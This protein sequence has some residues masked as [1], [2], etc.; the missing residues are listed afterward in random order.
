MICDRNIKIIGARQHNLNNV[1]LNIPYHRLTAVTGVSGCGKSSLVFDTV[2]AESQRAFLAGLN[3]S[4]YGN[5][6][7]DKPDVDRVEN[8]CPALSL[9]QNYYNC[10]PR[11]TVGTLTEIS[12][13]LRSLFALVLNYEEGQIYKAKDFSFNNPKVWCSACC[14][15]GEGYHVAVPALI[16]DESKT[17]NKGGITYFKGNESSLEYRTLKMA[18]EAFS[19][20]MDT[21]MSELPKDKLNILLNFDGDCVF[22]VRYKS[23][24]K[25]YRKKTVKFKGAITELKHKLKNINV[26][27]TFRSIEKFIASGKCQ[28]CGGMRLKPEILVK[29]VCGC[30]I[31]HVEKMS[32]EDVSAWLGRVREHY[33]MGKIIKA[34]SDIESQITPKLQALVDLK[35]G[36]LCLDRSVPTL[37]RGE[38]QRV[39]VADQLSCS[40]VG[41]LYILDEP[42]KGLH[43]RDIGCIIKATRQL[44]NRWNT[45]VAIEHNK[46]FLRY[47][48]KIVLMGPGGGPYGG[49]IVMQGTYRTVFGEIQKINDNV[50]AK[51]KI[52]KYM[53]FKDIYINNLHHIDCR[54]PLGVLTVISGVSGSGKS[55]LAEKVLFESAVRKQPVHCV[56]FK[57]EQ[58]YNK[59]FLVNQSPIGKTPRSNIVSYLNIYNEIRT[60]FA[61][62]EKAR[63]CHYRASDFSINTGEGRCEACLG[64][65]F[66]RIEMTYLS[67]TY[68]TCEECNGQRF[69]ENILQAKYHGYSINDVLNM[70]V[71]NAAQVFTGNPKIMSKLSCLI[72][73]GLGYIKLGQMSMTLSGGE[74]Q[75]IKLAKYLGENTAGHN[76]Y[77]LDE[78]TSGLSDMDIQKIS[79]V[80][81][82]IVD[83]GNTIVIVEHNIDYIKQNA[84]Y[85]IDMGNY[86]GK[87]GGQIVDAGSTSEIFARNK[88]SICI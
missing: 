71:D 27:S 18:C 26:P 39:R 45:V 33:K 80:I 35:V 14:G 3:S 15:L 20:D 28:Q 79:M 21:P 13:Y 59:A 68:V 46:E 37:S 9:T 48:D 31:S 47:A 4:V 57:T 54:I 22:H 38:M 73:I 6:I 78:P 52:D 75:R 16:P 60:L 44:V 55:T 5:K 56:K 40:L 84:D 50:L 88:A 10:N 12:S 58:K 81:N 66:K 42:C 23:G 64:T 1:S 67:D 72:D 87:Q 19:I 53:T 49:N 34:I 32:I 43:F 7:M 76:I 36:Y 2:Y 69:K 70:S 82:K 17:L 63:K 8:L 65:G 11:S 24:K 74:A 25:K 77:I 51:R 61:K 62:T 41:L 83:A 29:T 30:N 85:I 86:G